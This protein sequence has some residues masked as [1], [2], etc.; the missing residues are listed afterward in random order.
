MTKTLMLAAALLAG[1]WIQEARAGFRTPEALLRNV[2]G[3][4]GQGTPEWSRGLP[5]DEA[6]A[7]QFFTTRL[8]HAWSRAKPP[9]DFLVQATS[10]KIGAV[11]T[12][13]LRKQFDK[14]YLAVTFGNHGRPVSLNF[15]VVNDADEGWL[16]DD[17]ES[18]H[19][20]LS[21]LLSQHRRE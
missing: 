9:F 4:Y 18:P 21:L 20:S 8:R 14:T 6:T 11:S 15:I 3:Y 17:V 2:Y 1:C 13:V 5:H 16:I 19:D 10:W 12:A 7:R